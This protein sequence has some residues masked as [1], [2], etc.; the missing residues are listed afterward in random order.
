MSSVDVDWHEAMTNSA[1]PDRM[2]D[3]GEE[4]I[5]KEFF[6]GQEIRFPA[7]ENSSSTDF[8]VMAWYRGRA[9]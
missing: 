9:C 2:P 1:K 3:K 4:L 7:A 6:T 8:R 5:R